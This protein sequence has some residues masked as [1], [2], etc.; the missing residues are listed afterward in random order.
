[1][2]KSR[3]DPHDADSVLAFIRVDRQ[4]GGIRLDWKGGRE[5]WQILE[6]RENLA[7]TTE[8][9]TAIFAL[10]PPTALTNAVI[11]MGATNRNL[12]YRIRVAR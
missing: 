5:A 10:P 12:F 2:H 7:Y 3:P 6:Y 1:M 9:W 8:L 11:D 4:F